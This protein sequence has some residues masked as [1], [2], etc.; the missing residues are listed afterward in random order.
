MEKDSGLSAG[1]ADWM[2]VKKSGECTKD[3]L[4]CLPSMFINIIGSQDMKVICARSGN[5]CSSLAVYST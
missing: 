1:S 2:K 4:T 3:P 5:A